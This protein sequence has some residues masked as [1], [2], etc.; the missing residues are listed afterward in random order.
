MNNL[1][2]KYMYT[3]LFFSGLCCYAQTSA[4]K[5]KVTTS[6][7]APVENVNILLQGTQKGTVTDINGD[8]VL[9]GITP[10][11]HV[12]TASYISYVTAKKGIVINSSET[13]KVDFVLNEDNL[14]LDEVVVSAGR[15]PE[16][17]SE[18]PASITIVDSKQ[19]ELL[20]TSTTNISEIL[21]Y[22]IP[23]LAPSTGT[24]SSW[25]QTLRGRE[26]LI[27]VDGIPQSTPLR[28]GQVDIK[29]VQPNDISRIE[30]IKGSAAI[31]GNSGDGGIINYITKKPE[32]NQ[33]FSGNSNLWGTLNLSE[34]K[35]A[36][37]WGVQQSVT[38]TMDDF[39]YYVSGSYEKTGNKYDGNG[40]PLSPT[41]GLDNTK[42]ISTLGKVG[43]QIN[44]SQTVDLMFNHYRTRQES[45]FVPLLGHL[46][47]FNASGDYLVTPT[48]GVAPTAENPIPEEAEGSGVTTTNA[49]LKYTLSGIF[50]NTSKLETDLY[51]QKGKNIFF[52]D[53]TYFEN[54]GQTVVNT[55]KM[56]FRPVLNTRLNFSV[57]VSMSLT[58]GLDVLKDKT[59][60]GLL[61]GRVWTPNIDLLSIAP[62]VQA[63][64]K[65]KEEWV[66]KA[67]L[68]YDNMKAT[69]EDFSTLPVSPTRD[70]NFTD[71]INVT[72]GDIKFSN[73]SANIG[74]R[75]I[76]HDEFIPYI[77]FSQGFSLPDMG[78]VVRGGTST[79]V[80]NIN[81]E[82]IETN[83]YEFGFLSKFEHIRFEAVG[84]YT[85]SNLGIGLIRVEDTDQFIQSKNPQKI[86]GAEVAVDFT[87]FEDRLRFGSS[88]SYVE[89][90]THSPDDETN[91]SYIGGDVIA[92]PKVTAYVN[93]VPFD[94][95]ST[96]LRVIHVGD[97]KRFNPTENNGTFSYAYKQVPVT[98]YTL[99][100][101]SSTYKA[102]DKLSISLGINNLFNKFYLPPRSQ[103]AASL[104]S[105]NSAGEGANGRLS[106]SYN[107]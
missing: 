46:E 101:I 60:Q 36:L 78:R 54:G 21:E 80:K 22:A 104:G 30:V 91:L 19:L 82:A 32:R 39:S 4:V 84:F 75:Y 85:K 38:G 5:G 66:L 107:F 67:G 37:G 11:T 63:Q 83:N 57:P 55:E 95:L 86:Y 12:L 29:S 10:G 40:D 69:I 81:P 93:I 26:P 76:K 18:I 77:N 97:R 49:Q 1:I 6:N 13:L 35:D 87:Y 2:K 73:T 56:G 41:Y 20:G 92:P 14:N 52:Y 8:Y 24:F 61:D 103:W 43:Y 90:L 15:T 68:R 7:G 42:I 53:A 3:A 48:I 65:Y 88:Y 51:Y 25:G 45:P 50:D 79:N 44:E 16:R 100:N 96:A 105:Y 71:P 17:L 23:G 34:S 33:S 94:K 74:I 31:Y 99:V 72:G 62:F 102:T 58:Y 9:K 106:V 89:G 98:G 59:N 28:N 70:D 64:L 27:M 47:V